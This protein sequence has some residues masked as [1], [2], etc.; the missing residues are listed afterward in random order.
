MGGVQKMLNDVAGGCKGPAKERDGSPK[1]IFS[2][3]LL[4]SP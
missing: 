4:G 3:T 1:E 2:E